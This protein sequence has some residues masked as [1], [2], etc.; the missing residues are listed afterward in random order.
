VKLTW[1]EDDPE[2]NQ[3]TRRPLTRQEIEEADFKAY[4]ASSTSGS[5]SETSQFHSKESTQRK[6][7]RALPRDKLRAL[8]LDRGDEELP[9]GWARNEDGGEDDVDMEITFTP[10]LNDTREERDETTLEQYQRKLKE[11]RKKRKEQSKPKAGNKATAAEVKDDFFDEEGSSG[12]QS[13][14][15]HHQ[16]KRS[17]KNRGKREGKNVDDRDIPTTSIPRTPIT[18]EELALLVASDKPNAELKHFD[19]KSV[20]KAEKASKLKGKKR[21]KGPEEE[22]ETQDDF[23]IDLKDERFKSLHQDHAF[24]IDPSNPQRVPIS[25]LILSQL[26]LYILVSRRPRIWL[27]FWRNAPSR[28]KPARV[29]QKHQPR[30]VETRELGVC[31][32]WLRV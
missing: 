32:I 23:V 5:D 14:E 1:D 4:L 13:E 16:E 15:D 30:K 10:A 6:D 12:S 18:S 7:R 9:E 19:L 25:F 11:K 8:L 22:D 17:G 24:A 27:P 31:I 20:L 21:R 28:R 29:A 3:I 2:R 26:N